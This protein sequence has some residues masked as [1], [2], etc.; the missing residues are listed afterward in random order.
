VIADLRG[1]VAVVTGAAS[2]IGAAMVRRFAAEGMAVIGADIDLDGARRTLDGLADTLALPVDVADP[3]A[4]Q[5]LA[6]EVFA[7][8]GRVDLLCN[9][10]GVFQGGLSWERSHGDWDWT[11]GVNLY[12]IIHGITSF[13]PRMIAQDTEGHVVNTASIAAYVAGPFSSPYVVSKA[14]AFSLSECLAHD[15]AAVGSKIG[16]SVLTPSAVDTGI[17]QAERNRSPRYETHATEDSAMTVEFLAGMVATGLAPDEVVEP[18]V[19][20]IRTGEFLIPT[21]PSYVSQLDA[22]HD[23]LV[24]RRL[25]IIT[26]VD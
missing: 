2:G 14:A 16:V 15:L 21:K 20:A 8:H 24:D 10:A 12:G 26:S 11:F 22:R 1:K 17:A 23:A 5:A 13:V 19:R 6:D 9:N 3:D 7:R 18:V 4:V 25:P